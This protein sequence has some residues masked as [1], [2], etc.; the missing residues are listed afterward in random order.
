MWSAQLCI[1]TLTEGKFRRALN[2]V[3]PSSR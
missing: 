2:A 1:G 3:A